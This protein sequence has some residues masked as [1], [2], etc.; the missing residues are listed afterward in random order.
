MKGKWEGKWGQ[1]IMSPK[2]P[3]L[4]PPPAVRRQPDFLNHSQHRLLQCPTWS[5]FFPCGSHQIRAIFPN[6]R[7]C[8]VHWSRPPFYSSFGLPSLCSAAGV[9]CLSA[10][11][12]IVNSQEGP[13]QTQSFRSNSSFC[14]NLFL[15]LTL[16]A[17]P[18][19][20]HNVTIAS[21]E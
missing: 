15:K 6:Y 19:C 5:R 20:N 11:L 14:F 1:N 2:L 3:E 10:L 18:N 17:A 7:I 9:A 4:C 13:A 16:L 12:N 8:D 21:K